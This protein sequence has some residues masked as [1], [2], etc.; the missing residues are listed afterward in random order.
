M[1]GKK[2]GE[3]FIVYKLEFGED[4]FITNNEEEAEEVFNEDKDRIAQYYYKE[5]D[6]DSESE[7][8]EEGYVKVYFTAE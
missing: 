7:E 8:Y 2:I 3:Y 5:W 1:T 4:D 6:W